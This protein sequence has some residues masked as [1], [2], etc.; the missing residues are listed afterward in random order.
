VK[1]SSRRQPLLPWSRPFGWLGR[2]ARQAKL[3]GSPI[4]QLD[5]I[6]RGS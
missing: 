4:H 1:N 2:G 3:P 5:G 6:A